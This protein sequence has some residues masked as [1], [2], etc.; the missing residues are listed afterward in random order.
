[1]QGLSCING[2]KNPLRHQFYPYLIKGHLPSWFLSAYPHANYLR[3]PIQLP[4]PTALKQN[5]LKQWSWDQLIFVWTDLTNNQFLR[6]ILI[7][8]LWLRSIKSAEIDRTWIEDRSN[9]SLDLYVH[10]SSSYIGMYIHQP[11]DR[12]TFDLISWT[13]SV[14]QSTNQ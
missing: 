13:I 8:E 10:W 14:S 9:P 6:Y 4:L 12:L 1:M 3:K 11:R 5:T 2:T 7:V